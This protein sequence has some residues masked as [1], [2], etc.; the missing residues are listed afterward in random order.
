MGHHVKVY[1][2]GERDSAFWVAMGPMFASS[3][4][5]RSL[6]TIHDD[7]TT[8]T[9][10][11][12]SDKGGQVIGF[13]CL[14]VIRPGDAEL[15]HCYVTPDQREQGVAE[16]L[17]SERINHARKIGV[18]RL[19][20]LATL[21]HRPAMERAGFVPAQKQRGKWNYCNMEMSL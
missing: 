18:K 4:V 10:F 1:L 15:C 9:W 14:R 8:D 20:T 2:P 7:P 13:A 16:E 6:Q 5:R 19:T 21:E 17:T 11:V 3:V 12:S